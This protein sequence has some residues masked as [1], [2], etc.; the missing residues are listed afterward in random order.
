MAK[1]ITTFCYSSIN[2]ISACY[3]LNIV[4]STLLTLFFLVGV[5]VISVL[6]KKL[7]FS[8][9]EN[10]PKITKLLSGR[11]SIHSLSWVLPFLVQY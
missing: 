9:T 4:F 2:M 1:D 11:A 10:L 3:M 8:E 6:M 7:K 5:T